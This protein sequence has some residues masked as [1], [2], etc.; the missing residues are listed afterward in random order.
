MA[1]H[2]KTYQLLLLF[3][4]SCFPAETNALIKVQDKHCMKHEVT[5][6]L[7]LGML[8]FLLWTPDLLVPELQALGYETCVLP[9]HVLQAEAHTQSLLVQERGEHIDQCHCRKILAFCA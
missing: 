5:Q 1:K 7:L 3:K 6:Q 4:H 9:Q 8:T 2:R